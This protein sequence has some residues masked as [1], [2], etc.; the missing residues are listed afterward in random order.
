MILNLNVEY[1]GAVV[2]V[3][4]CA[5]D[6]DA[7]DLTFR[8]ESLQAQKLHLGAIRENPPNHTGEFETMAAEATG[9]VDVLVLW[10][11]VDDEM[12][13]WSHRVET[14]L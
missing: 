5:Q 1:R 9:D 3:L 11:T 2:E 8:R 10:M 6:D 13:V 4:R 14:S 12:A 7:F